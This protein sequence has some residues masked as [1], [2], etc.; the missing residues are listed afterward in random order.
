MAGQPSHFKGCSSLNYL[1]TSPSSCHV[2][3]ALVS[4]FCSQIRD[5]TE[6]QSD[7][8]CRHQQGTS[9]PKNTTL[10]LSTQFAKHTTAYLRYRA[11]S[12]QLQA[13][14]NQLQSSVG[15]G[16]C[17]IISHGT[18][19]SSYNSSVLCQTCTKCSAPSFKSPRATACPIHRANISLPI[20]DNQLPMEGNQ[21]T[22]S[23]PVW[24]SALAPVPLVSAGDRCM[25]CRRL[26][27]KC[28]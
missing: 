28:G 22:Q 5:H 9:T 13:I 8:T 24:F 26:C 17:P 19:V 11:A 1:T 7:H 10:L 6:S 23:H 15:R 18:K 2:A 12:L 25:P 4:R 21:D 20:E 14:L 16:D 27:S 3:C